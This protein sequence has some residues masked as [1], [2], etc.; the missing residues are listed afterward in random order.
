MKS[1]FRDIKEYMTVKLDKSKV[2]DKVMFFEEGYEKDNLGDFSIKWW[3]DNLGDFQS[4]LCIISV[5]IV[6]W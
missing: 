2:Y 6:E 3:W 5:I 1:D 4:G